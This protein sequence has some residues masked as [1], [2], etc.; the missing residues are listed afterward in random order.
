M[1]LKSAEV[2]APLQGAISL[3]G[4]PGVARNALTPGYY[5]SRLRREIQV[6]K[7]ISTGPNSLLGDPGV[8]RETRLPLANVCHG[9]AVKSKSQNQS[10]P[11]RTLCW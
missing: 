6:A 1:R 11:A 9:Y 10:A 7:S 2:L 8:A 5:L 4:D 3:L